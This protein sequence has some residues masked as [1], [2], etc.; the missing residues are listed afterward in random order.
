MNL[1]KTLLKRIVI[2]LGQETNFSFLFSSQFLEK[3][4]SPPPYIHDGIWDGGS[5]VRTPPFSVPSWMHGGLSDLQI[6]IFTLPLSV[7]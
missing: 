7:S 6:I 4:M 5:K 2:D 1:G 3:W